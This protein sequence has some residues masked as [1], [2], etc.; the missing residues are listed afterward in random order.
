LLMRPE[1][2]TGKTH[3]GDEYG[4]NEPHAICAVTKSTSSHPCS[5]ILK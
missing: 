3:N 5:L 2:E 1:F 4:E